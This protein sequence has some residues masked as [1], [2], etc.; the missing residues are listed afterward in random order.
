MMLDFIDENL[1]QQ[2]LENRLTHF[3]SRVRAA[4]IHIPYLRVS[5]VALGQ[6]TVMEFIRRGWLARPE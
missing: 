3:R 2:T 5:G 6:D 4:Y 1:D